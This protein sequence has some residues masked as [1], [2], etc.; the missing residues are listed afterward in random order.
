MSDDIRTMA[1]RVSGPNQDAAAALAKMQHLNQELSD[2]HGSPEDTV[3]KEAEVTRLR[4][5][6]FAL[7]SEAVAKVDAVTEQIRQSD[8]G[9]D[10]EP[11]DEDDEDVTVDE[12]GEQP[13]PSRTAPADQVEDPTDP[14][15]RRA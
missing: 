6:Q 9:G 15:A 8:E 7:A 13:T 5:E 10:N 14:R 3:E 2:L 1:E 12:P 11:D 4:D